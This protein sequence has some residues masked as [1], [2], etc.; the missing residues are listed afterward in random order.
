MITLKDWMELVD[1]RITEGS[2]Y[3]WQ[4]FGPNAYCLTSWN[5]SHN[6]WSLNIT[7]D[8]QTQTVYMVEVC[9]YLNERAYRII[10]S[11]FKFAYDDEAAGHQPWANQAW[12]DVDYIDLDVDQDF[13]E[14]AQAIV[15]GEDY[16]TRVQIEVNLEDDMLYKLMT[17]AHEQDITLNQLLENALREEVDRVRSMNPVIQ[18]PPVPA[19]SFTQEQAQEAVRQARGKMMKGKK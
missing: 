7:F 6:G 9:D 5:G 11:N 19:D 3:G 2:D 10:D 4:C 14:K 1:Y 17:L 12:D 8:T 16:D 15:A 18:E 13:L